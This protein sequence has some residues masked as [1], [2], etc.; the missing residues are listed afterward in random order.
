M[1]RD[2]LREIVGER[3]VERIDLDSGER[4]SASFVSPDHKN[5]EGDVIW[6]FRRRDGGEPVFVY[7]LMEFQSRPDPS[8]PV[9]LMAYVSLFYQSLMKSQPAGGWKKLPLVI[10]V[11]VYNGEEPWNVSRDLGSLIGDLDP[12]AEI[13]RPQLRY[14]LVDESRYSREALVELDSPVAALFCIEK[15]QDSGEV[16]ASVERLRRVNP[17]LE[18]SLKQAFETWLRKV[19]QPR[20]ASSGE[21][22]EETDPWTLEEDDTMLAERMDRWYRQAQEKG[23]QEGLQEGRREGLQEGRQ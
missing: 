18:P 23:L 6:K 1:I 13:Y 12:S 10:P 15:S 19:I 9:R 22:G 3:W 4:V 16:G 8:M 11:V 7:L 21:A 2:L 20:W 14:L 17:P 5:R